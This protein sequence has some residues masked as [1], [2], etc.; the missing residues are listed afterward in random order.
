MC[1]CIQ[2]GMDVSGVCVCVQIGMDVSGVCV[3]RLD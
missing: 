2:I 1:V 3:R